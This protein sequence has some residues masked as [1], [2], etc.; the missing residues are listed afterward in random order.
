MSGASWEGVLFAGA[1]VVVACS[2]GSDGG[3]IAGPGPGPTEPGEGIERGENPFG[4]LATSGE[5]VSS[6][7]EASTGT[8]ACTTCSDLLSGQFNA[9]VCPGSEAAIGALGACACSGDCNGDCNTSVCTGAA[10][11]GACAACLTVA[12]PDALQDCQED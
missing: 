10:L 4:F 9:G 8:G 3:T 12:C 6:S 2:G 11:D 5:T 1:L 7:A